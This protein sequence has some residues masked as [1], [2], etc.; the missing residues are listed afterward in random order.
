MATVVPTPPGQSRSPPRASNSSSLLSRP[1]SA[2]P[3]LGLVGG[4]PLGI[5]SLAEVSYVH[6]CMG[7]LIHG[8]VAESYPLI[9]IGIIRVRAGV[10]VP[11]RHVNDSAFRQNG[12]SDI[13]VDVVVHPVE[14]EMVHVAEQARG[15]VG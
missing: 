7:H 8:A 15:P 9:G 14:I 1:S 2:F 3:R 5:L 6:P 4:G 11:R 12:R 10:I 13:C